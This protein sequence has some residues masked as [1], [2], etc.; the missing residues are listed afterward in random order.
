MNGAF[1]T[2]EM[3]LFG[4]PADPRRH[5]ASVRAGSSMCVLALQKQPGSLQHFTSD[6]QQGSTFSQRRPGCKEVMISPKSSLGS[7]SILPFLILYYR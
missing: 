3:E 7:Q 2:W 6:A 4:L 5:S 1:H